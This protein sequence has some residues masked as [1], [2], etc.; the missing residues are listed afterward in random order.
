MCL[1][2]SIGLGVAVAC[3]IIDIVFDTDI[4][5]IL[6]PNRPTDRGFII[7]LFSR[8]Q[9]H[10]QLQKRRIYQVS[11]TWKMDTVQRSI[12]TISHYHISLDNSA[13]FASDETNIPHN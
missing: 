10:S 13:H 1:C 4:S 6:G 11:V 7:L 8:R 5:S 3:G 9:K 12:L 2:T